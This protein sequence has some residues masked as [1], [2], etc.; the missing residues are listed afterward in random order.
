MADLRNK[1]RSQ[2]WERYL[3]LATLILIVLAWYAGG[4]QSK[5]DSM[6]V[7]K[8]LLP[9]AH[10]FQALEHDTYAAWADEADSL[11]LGYVKVAQAMGYGGPMTV[12]VAV[13]TRAEV[14]GVGVVEHKDSPTYFERVLKNS[15]IKNLM[16]KSHESDLILGRDID[17]VSGATK[18]SFAIVESTRQ[19][20]RAIASRQLGLQVLGDT[21]RK[22]SFGPAE[23]ILILL[24][25]L[26]IVGRRKGFK[27]T[28]AV[29]WVSLLAGLIVLGFIYDSPLTIAMVN[30]F[31]LGFWP[32]WH[33][34]LYT[35]LLV[36]GVLAL[37]LVKGKNPYCLWFCPFGAAQECI[38]KITKVKSRSV[39]TYRS[40]LKWMHR[41]AALSAILLAL[42]LRDPGLTSYEVFGALFKMWGSA[43]QFVII[44]LVFFM[45]LYTLRPWCNYLCPV[46]PVEDYLRMMK[47]WLK[48]IWLGKKIQ[49]A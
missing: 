16:G 39:G 49:K 13:N 5:A 34:N 14:I 26:G 6:P 23:G 32:D 3:G 11:L 37:F 42:L 22:V 36:G 10:H 19:A 33:S 9:A 38:G 25:A 46:R 48:E 2:R 12:A 20:I 41:S 17:A 27:Y 47:K 7:L 40:L 21:E 43:Y 18:S 24:F 28:Q 15:L 8:R 45:S 29:R 4:L 44:A 1:N 30:Q 31:L 35:Y